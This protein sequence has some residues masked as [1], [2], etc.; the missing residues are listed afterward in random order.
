MGYSQNDF[1]VR[2][3]ARGWDLQSVLV[4][5]VVGHFED[6]RMGPVGFSVQGSGSRVQGFGCRAQGSGY[7]VQGAGF[8]VCGLG[9]RVQGFGLRF[10]NSSARRFLS[11]PLTRWAEALPIILK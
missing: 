7:R 4:E 5:K 9:F 2:S 10:S 6:V 3:V 1:V 11:R 8:T